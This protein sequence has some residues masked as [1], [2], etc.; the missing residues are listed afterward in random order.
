MVTIPFTGKRKGR[1]SPDSMTLGEHLGELRRRVIICAIAFLVAATIAVVAYEPI[2][3]FLLHPLCSVDATTGH[4]SAKGSSSL[5]IASNGSCNLFVTSP[6]DGLSLRVKIALFGG[7][8]LAS[9]IILFQIWRFVTPGLKATERKYAIPF[10]LS[11][12][13]LFLLGAATAYVTLP[14]ALSWL[15]SVGGPNLQAI[16]DP[17]PY[18]GLILLMMTI[19]GLT[20]EFPVILVS[21]ELARVVTPARLLKSWR[22]AVIIIVIIAAVF[23][24]SSDPFS[25]FAL[26]IP[27]VVFYFLS[28]GIGKLL[29]R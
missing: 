3:N 20:F 15:K 26:A 6:L 12:F 8:V 5:L 25:M 29:G 24:P 28:I 2:L 13:V 17:I 21:L 1:P 16:Y 9:P 19:F 18:L 7:L 4:H 10:V 14:H 22:W 11:A 23:T 27:L